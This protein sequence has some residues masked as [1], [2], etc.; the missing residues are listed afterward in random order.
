[1]STSVLL[2][3]GTGAIGDYLRGQLAADGFRVIVTSRQIRAPEPN[4]HFLVG[5]ARDV[6]FLQN[7]LK[8]EKPDAVVDFLTYSTPEF[9][10]RR[11]ILLNGTGHY[12]FLS[13]Y[14]VYAD[15]PCLFENSPRLLDTIND[16]AYLATDEYA[17]CKARGENLLHEGRSRNW[18]ILRP[19][20][21]YSKNRFQ[22]GC[23]E[24]YT[25]LW[26][27]ARK[28]PSAIPSSMLDKETTLTW[29]GDTAKMISRLV[30]NDAALGETFNIST[31]EHRSWRYVADTYKSAIGLEI[32]D[33]P[34]SEYANATG[35]AKTYYDRM[36]NRILDN[37][38][39]L[40]ATGLDGTAFADLRT[41]LTREVRDF[42]SCG[43]E[44]DS[45]RARRAFVS[46]NAVLDKFCGTRIRLSNLSLKERF[47]YLKTLYPRMN[48]FL[49]FR[50]IRSV[51]RALSRSCI[52][53]HQ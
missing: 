43:R 5:N 38:K 14:R 15:V 9:A 2:L 20:I 47:L 44:E 46:Q 30:C 50:G 49:P 42:V 11:D 28:L 32:C 24:A 40:A 26:R 17:L 10:A 48:R 35:K 13:S 22:L 36:F 52:W 19:S 12:L 1:M 3:G 16:P 41:M 6:P 25:F 23:L 39:I 51:K 4:V 53:R 33:I 18:T 8:N 37:S 27:H 34:L 29:A 45:T 7:V 31:S 21:T